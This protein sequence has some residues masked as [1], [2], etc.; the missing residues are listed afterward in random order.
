MAPASGSLLFFSSW[1]AFSNQALSSSPSGRT[2]FSLLSVSC[3]DLDLLGCGV[4]EG[5]CELARDRRTN[6][7]LAGS[8]SP[9][10][11]KS[12]WY[13]DGDDCDEDEGERKA[14]EVD[15]ADDA[16]FFARVVKGL[17]VRTLW[18]GHCLAGHCGRCNRLEIIE[19]VSVWKI[20]SYVTR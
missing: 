20:W 19:R 5:S 17:T 13:S 4:S 3:A 18:L 10:F 12:F 6:L 9:P 8:E 14:D 16:S 2:D 1:T 7:E 11:E 15:E